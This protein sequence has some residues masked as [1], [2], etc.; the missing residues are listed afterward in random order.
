MFA[1]FGPWYQDPL[2]PEFGDASK[3]LKFNVEEAKQLMAA[4]GLEEGVADEVPFH[5]TTAYGGEFIARAEAVAANLAAIGIRARLVPEAYNDFVSN[6]FLGLF[7]GMA[8]SLPPV[9]TDVDELLSDGFLPGSQRNLSKINDSTLNDRIANQR[10]IADPAAR[11][12]AVQDIMKYAVEQA[13]YASTVMGETY[14]LNQE[15]VSDW[16]TSTTWGVGTESFL[17]IK[18]TKT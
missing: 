18:T 10:T 14:Y 2:S 12:S 1:S 6:T 11:V 16:A 5:Y 15:W 9:Y 3:Y 4:A 13:Y 7:D 17:A 8:F